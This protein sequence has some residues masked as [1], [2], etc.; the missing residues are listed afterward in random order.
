VLGTLK[1]VKQY[2]QETLIILAARTSRI[3]REVIAS[4]GGFFDETKI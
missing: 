2:T 4:R 3:M 1:R